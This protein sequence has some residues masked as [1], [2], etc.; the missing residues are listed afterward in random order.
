MRSCVIRLAAASALALALAAL[1]SASSAL[2]GGGGVTV[3]AAAGTVAQVPLTPETVLRFL[4]S[5]ES[6]EAVFA[7]LD[8]QYEP[9]DPDA[10]M[11][12][13]AYLVE[14]ADA[15]ARLESEVRAAGWSGF[16]DWFMTAQSIM[17]A[18]QWIID[19]PNSEDMDAAEAEIRAMQGISEDVRAELLANLADARSQIDGLRP[20]QANLDAVRPHVERLDSVLGNR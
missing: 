13:L 3:A 19:P 2:A 11:D 18:R 4:E 20:S 17:L 7:E 8:D 12:E 1:P 10:V 5:W 14:S 16:E 9:G 6:V 15:V